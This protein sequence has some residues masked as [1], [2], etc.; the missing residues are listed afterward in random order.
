MS[1]KSKKRAHGT[2]A[3]SSRRRSPRL[4]LLAAALIVVALLTAVAAPRWAPLRR[5]IGLAPLAPAAAPQGGGGGLQLAKEYIYAGGRLIATEEPAA[6]QAPYGGTARPLPGTLQ[7]EDFDEGGEGIAY[8]DT[9]PVDNVMNGYRPDP[10]GV[11]IEGC[12]DAG[13]GFN[14]G[15]TWGGEWL[16]YTV[17]VT[18][19]GTYDLGVRVASGNGGGGTFHVDVDG[20]NVTGAMSVPNT[21]AWQSYQTVTRTGVTL[22]AGLHL[23]RLSLDTE[24]PQG[25]VANFNYLSVSAGTVGEA[26]TNLVASGASTSSVALSWT[27]PAGSVVGYVV[28]RRNALNAQPVEIATNSS[29]TVFTD[30]TLAAGDFSYLYRVKAVFGNG[31]SPYSNTDIATT[32][33]FTDD[34]LVGA[35]DP[36]G[37]PATVVYAR[38]LTEL[39]RAVNA[40]R[41]LV[42]GLGAAAWTYPDPVSSPQR[43][44]Y[45]ED[46]KDLRDRLGEALGPLG[47]TPP[48]YVDGTLTRNVTPVKRQHFQQLRDAVR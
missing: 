3:P 18:A 33:V 26:P 31:S 36:Q 30:T 15:W 29:A 41:G 45:L 17:E 13:G 34:P 37:R 44:I 43:A 21:G 4:R 48:S 27:A 46:V 9:D 5:A 6:P 38:H 42:A 25:G 35:N 24:G 19:A 20:N 23:L 8:H 1:K 7:A 12:G 11:D 22:T 16:E 32:V 2:A 14:V 47:V 39:R 40:V 28:E 10:S